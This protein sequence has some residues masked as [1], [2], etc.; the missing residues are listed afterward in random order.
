MDST[1][2]MLNSRSE[3]HANGIGNGSDQLG[4]NFCA[5][6]MLHIQ[7]V[8]PHLFG[9]GY[10]NDDG[11]G[12]GQYYIPR[13]NHRSRQDYLRGFGIQMWT[14]GCDVTDVPVA[15][16][17]PGFGAGFK[18][19]A[20]N[21]YPALVPLHPF[22]EVLA[23]P[24]NRVTIDES[25]TDRYGVPLM[26][27]SVEFGDNEQKM[28]RHMY[29]TAEEI[30]HTA[31]AEIFPFDRA[32]NDT[33]GSAIREHGTCRM[34]AD[35]KSSVLNEFNQMH[36]VDNLFVV[37]GSAFTNASE[38]NPTLSILALSWRATDYLAEEMRQGNL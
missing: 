12:G 8:L 15:C 11:T 19:E 17:T 35:P 38:K 24:E 36:E 26:K 13:F 28:R 32:T 10:Q 29:D 34:G 16:N 4:R 27:V 23:R 25:R 30:L 5:Q 7:G 22:G 1:R 14:T 6:I 21:R 31:G 2:I 18:A 33:P 37:D 9:R 20:K 3:R